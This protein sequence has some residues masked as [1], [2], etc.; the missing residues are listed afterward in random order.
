M[1]AYACLESAGVAAD[2]ERLRAHPL[3]RGVRRNTQHEA[4]PLFLA[5]PDFVAG[6]RRAGELDLVCDICVRDHQLEGALALARACPD[7]SIVLNHLGKPDLTAPDQG[8]WRDGIS[9][10]AE[11]PSVSC[12]ISVVVHTDADPALTRD[13]AAPIVRHAVSVFG[14]D[15]VLFASNWPVSTAVIGYGAWARMVR[16]VLAGAAPDELERLFRGNARGIYGLT[17]APK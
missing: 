15:R 4:D 12:K 11:Q 5:R 16:E 9:R 2:L 10:L 8:R 17:A 7:T 14:W 3:V 13:L 1:V 6:A